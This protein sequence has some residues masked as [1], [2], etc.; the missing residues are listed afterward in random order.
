[1]IGSIPSRIFL[2]FRE[3]HIIM[4][5]REILKKYWGYSTFRPL[6]EDVIQSVMSGNDTLALFPT[7]GGKSIL[8]QVP[9]MAQEGLTL[10]VSP[11]IALMKDQVSNLRSRGI[12]AAALFSG[13]HSRERD[14][15]YANAINGNTKLLYVSPERLTTDA[16]REN[17]PYLDIN[18]VAVDEAHCISQWG[19]DFRPPYL[20]IAEIRDFIPKVPVLALTATATPEVVEDIQKQLKFTTENVFRKSFGR[21]NLIYVVQKEE[22]KSGRL[23]RVIRNIGGTGVVYARRRKKTV[24]YA[25]ILKKRGFSADYYHAG[26][27]MPVRN[28]KQKE[29]MENKTKIMVSTNAFGMGIDK[30]DVRFVVHLDLP[31]SIESYFQ[32]AGRGGRD[33]NRSY[34]VILYD[35]NDV[36][37][38]REQLNTAFPPISEIKR[39]YEALGNYFQLAVGS[40]EES[41]FE[42]DIRQFSE[43]YGIKP[44]ALYNALK[45]LEKDG[46]IILNEAIRNPSRI[47]MDVDKEMLYR[48]Q[49]KERNLDGFIKLILRSYSGLFTQFT[50]ID[51]QLIARRYGSTEKDVVNKLKYLQNQGLLT[52]ISANSKPLLTFSKERQEKK[53]LYISQE[54]Y[55]LR[56]QMQEKRLNALINYVESNSTCRS[57]QLLDYFGET[58]S[59]RCGKCDVCV[60]ENKLDLSRTEFESISNQLKSILKDYPTFE[61]IQNRLKEFD[62]QKLLEI[63]RFLMDS[64]KIGQNEK[65]RYFWKEKPN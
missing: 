44:F 19:Y 49:L 15:V 40:G 31:D 53:N 6:Q 20:Q 32:E 34:A 28:R 25:H 27:E 45:F 50:A 52:Y 26:V 39:V 47:H 37:T 46:Y 29:W 62:K 65:R 14:L 16:F 1:M 9:A 59:R 7:G 22:D 51:E 10:V 5:I 60:R 64:E 21:S 18:L 11:L 33:G 41:T 4:E 30:P 38:A 3:A 57:I 8:Y 13:L 42:F 17:L 36:I 35:N 61:E 2:Y 63:I 23:E 43:R 24:E 48:F 54:N 12:D 55:Q 56:K 58:G